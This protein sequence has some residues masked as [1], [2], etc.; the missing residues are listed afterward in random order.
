MHILGILLFAVQVGFALHV[1]RSGRDRYWI[2]LILF[3]PALG[4]AIYF[5]SEVLPTLRGNYKVQRAGRSILNSV[6]PQREVR[7]LKD[8]IQLADTF[9]NRRALADAC[10]SAGHLEEAGQL[11]QALLQQEEYNP[12][13]MQNLALCQYLTKDYSTARQTLT[14]LIAHNPD[15]HSSEG[16]LLYAKT[17]EALGETEQALDE[18]RVVVQSYAGE[19]ARYR[20]ALLL[21]AS[22]QA[23]EASKVF[24]EILT[25]TRHSPNYYRRAQKQW[26][27]LAKQY[28]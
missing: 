25:R 12:H 17:L 4:C 11:Y 9:E 18:Y 15:Y 22:G 19:E 8:Q 23:H 16:H 6:D 26:I 2:Y 28:A 7:R 5:F 3:L 10:V 20:F 24:N 21:K 1:I 14:E 13:I 27:D